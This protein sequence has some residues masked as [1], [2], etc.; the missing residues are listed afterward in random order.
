MAAAFEGHQEIVSMLLKVE[1]IDVNQAY[2]QYGQ[3]PLYGAAEKAIT[4]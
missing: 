1:G 4:K 3:T 2:K